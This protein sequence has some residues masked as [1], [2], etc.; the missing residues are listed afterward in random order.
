[1]VNFANFAFSRRIFTCSEAQFMPLLEKGVHTVANRL[2]KLVSP[3]THAF[4]DYALAGSF[5][6]AGVAALKTSEKAAISAFIVAGAELTMAI[7]TDYPGG[8]AKLISLPSHL[9]VDTGMSGLVGS[10]PNLMGFSEERHSWFFRGQ[11]MAMAALA[12]LTYITEHPE[13]SVR[14]RAA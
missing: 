1:V 6:V 11:A 10:M 8:V 2:P 13:A 9:K 12:A 7:L 3:R 5:L 14:H 4:V